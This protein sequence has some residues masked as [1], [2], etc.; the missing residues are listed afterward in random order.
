MIFVSERRNPEDRPLVERGHQGPGTWRTDTYSQVRNVLAVG[1][2]ARRVAPWLATTEIAKA[3]EC[4]SRL[5]AFSTTLPF[6]AFGF[7]RMGTR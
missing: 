2:A 6:W 5:A 3:R 7:D 4:A 1:L